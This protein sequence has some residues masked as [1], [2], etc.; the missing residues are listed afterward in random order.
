MK[1]IALTASLLASSLFPINAFAASC[2]GY[3]GAIG[4][5]VTPQE[6]GPKIISSMIKLGDLSIVISLDKSVKI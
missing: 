3:P 5:K 6:N 1:K 4:A 2:E